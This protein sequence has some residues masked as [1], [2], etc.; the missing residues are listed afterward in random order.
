MRLSRNEVPAMVATFGD[1][2]W[3]AASMC[4]ESIA[5]NRIGAGAHPCL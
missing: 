5:D 1:E 2:W 4:R 3:G